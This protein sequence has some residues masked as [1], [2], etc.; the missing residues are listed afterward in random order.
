MRPLRI[1]LIVTTLSLILTPDAA[2]PLGMRVFATQGPRGPEL[3]V[4]TRPSQTGRL[5]PGVHAGVGGAGAAEARFE[6]D[7][8]LDAGLLAHLAT[9]IHKIYKAIEYLSLALFAAI[10]TLISRRVQPYYDAPPWPACCI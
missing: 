5:T 7:R 6:I 4:G 8:P 10:A 2:G 3:A 1:F 9:K